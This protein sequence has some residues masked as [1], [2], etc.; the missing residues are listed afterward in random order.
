MKNVIASSLPLLRQPTLL[1]VD[2]QL[3]NLEVL[4]QIIEQSQL[5]YTVL[6]AIHATMALEIIQKRKPDL[7][8]TDWDMPEIDGLA[9]IR[10]LKANPLT[11]E[12]PVIMC[13]GVMT[14]S[15]DL[16]TALNAGATDYLRKPIDAIEL[17]ARIQATLR[18]AASYQEIKRL[19]ES[20]DVMFSLIAHDLL[21]STGQ[22][23]QMIELLGLYAR[24]DWDAFERHLHQA[25]A[26]AQEGQ[27]LLDNLLNWARYRFESRAYPS[28]VIVLRELA[29]SLLQRIQP[30]AD[31]KNIELALRINR[32]ITVQ[33]SPDLLLAILT[34]LLDNALKF[35]QQGRIALRAR[36]LPE[37]TLI[38]VVDTGCGIYHDEIP[39]LYQGRRARPHL[40]EPGQGAGLGLRICQELLQKM[41]SVLQIE[42]RLGSGSTFSF[43]LPAH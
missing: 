5:P 24:H 27:R 11:A 20:K 32:E 39:L 1:I 34:Q 37:G 38:E 29:T 33:A 23:T 43:V 26:R 13:T 10:T 31:A 2:D 16:R 22:M 40:R 14:S 12:I 8:I 19:N 6:R 42:S 30:Q 18:L 4:V 9:F 17:Q 7:I 25:Q 35:T 21:E 36:S 15:E 28:E 41:D 3:N